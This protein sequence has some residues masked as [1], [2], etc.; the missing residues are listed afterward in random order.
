VLRVLVGGAGTRIITESAKIVSRDFFTELRSSAGEDQALQG[1]INLLQHL[2][3]LYGTRI[4][5]A[6]FLSSAHGA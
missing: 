3:A 4:K 6:F 2:T 5:D 1:T